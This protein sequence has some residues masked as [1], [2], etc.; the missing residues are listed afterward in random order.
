MLFNSY[1]FM[2]AFLPATL[3]VYYALGRRGGGAAMAF[4]ATAEGRRPWR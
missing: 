3:A 2:F 4:L 1:A